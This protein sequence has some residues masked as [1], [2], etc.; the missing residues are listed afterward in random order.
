M[1]KPVG[2]SSVM[3]EIYFGG[4][5]YGVASTYQEAQLVQAEGREWLRENRYTWPNNPPAA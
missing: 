4:M 1:I 3:Y 5:L 2:A